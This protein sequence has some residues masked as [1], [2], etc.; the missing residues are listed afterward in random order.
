MFHVT[1]LQ[2]SVKHLSTLLDTTLL[3]DVERVG[4][5]NSSLFT[6]K[7]KIKVKSTSFKM[8]SKNVDI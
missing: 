4:L 3:Y 1:V 2:G 8:V 5:T 6:P 7:N